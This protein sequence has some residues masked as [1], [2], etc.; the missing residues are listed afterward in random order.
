MSAPRRVQRSPLY[1][2]TGPQRHKIPDVRG[3]SKADAVKAL[4][5]LG[6]TVV[7]TDKVNSPP[8]LL[9]KAVNTTPPAGTDTAVNLGDRRAHGR[10]PKVTI[11]ELVGET[12][13]RARAILKQLGLKMA[14]VPGDSEM[15]RGEVVTTS[16][17]AGTTVT[18]DQTVT[19]TVSRGN[20][21]I[22]PNLV[23]KTPG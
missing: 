16:P 11:P 18:D 23:G 4:T 13:D 22:V 17:S 15:P 12:E 6:F 19:I 10:G 7:K 14:V 21:F 20:M 1:V 8:E 9:D 5:M 2:S 3:K